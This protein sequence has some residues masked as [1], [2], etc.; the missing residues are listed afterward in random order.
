[1]FQTPL[2]TLSSS[3]EAQELQNYGLRYAVVDAAVF[4]PIQYG[5]QSLS[6]LSEEQKGSSS[7]DMMATIGRESI[8]VNAFWCSSRRLEDGVSVVKNKSKGTRSKKKESSDTFPSVAK[9]R[10]VS[11]AHPKSLWK[12][13]C[14]VVLL[15]RIRCGNI[16]ETLQTAEHRSTILKQN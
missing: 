2:Y 1:M 13:S 11:R 12:R 6:S 5:S 15:T 7:E 3:F 8:T 14:V 9:F 4:S 16:F 10:S